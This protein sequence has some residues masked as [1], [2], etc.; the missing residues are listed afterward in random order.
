[1]KVH[2]SY[3]MSS[4]HQNVGEI[5]TIQNYQSDNLSFRLAC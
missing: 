1:M 5:E 2:L 4:K 3:T